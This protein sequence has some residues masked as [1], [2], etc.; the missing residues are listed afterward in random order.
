M[1]VCQATV[2]REQNRYVFKIHLNLDSDEESLWRFLGREF[3][4]EGAEKQK[5]RLPKRLDR[6]REMRSIPEVEERR[7][8]H[9]GAS[10]CS[11]T[12]EKGRAI[13]FLNLK[14]SFF[15]GGGLYVDQ[16]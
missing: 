9:D 13:I 14:K 8:V 4:A 5:L 12:S 3:Q 1:H 7:K 16:V 10:L 15:G 6:A 11:K 2:D